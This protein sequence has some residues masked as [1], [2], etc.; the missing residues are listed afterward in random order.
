[1]QTRSSSSASAEL[2]PPGFQF[3]ASHR[4]EA[5]LQIVD[6][7]WFRGKLPPGWSVVNKSRSLSP[8]SNGKSVQRHLTGEVGDRRL[9]RAVAFFNDKTR[10]HR[11]VEYAS[12]SFR[13]PKG[14]NVEEYPRK[15]SYHVDKYYVERRTGNHT[16]QQP[17]MLLQYHR[18]NS[19]D[20]HLPDG[21]IVEKKPRRNSNLHWPGTGNNFGSM[22]AVERYLKATGNS[23]LDSVSMGRSER[24]S[25]TGF[26]TE[27]ID[28]NPPE[29]VK[30]VLTSPDG[31]MFSA[32]MSGSD[33][34]SSVKQKWSEAF[35]PG[36]LL[37]KI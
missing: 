4:R 9:T 24:L 8:T 28:Q 25:L 16:D 5:Q 21:W 36:P 22:A 13:L 11:S 6:P 10:N 12:K 27:V 15:N 14:W 29:R 32:N 34:S 20:F 2:V 26:Q 1:M 35:V 37:T 33:V 7:N 18:V 23:T 17:L 30:W 31:N 3:P 19:K